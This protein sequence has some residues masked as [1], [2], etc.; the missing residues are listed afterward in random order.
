MKLPFMTA[1]RELD[2]RHKRKKKAT[3][4]WQNW[5]GL[6]VEPI[7]NYQKKGVRYKHT[8][9]Q[10]S[11]SSNSR[12]LQPSRAGYE[13]TAITLTRR[14]FHFTYSTHFKGVYKAKSLTL[15]PL[16]H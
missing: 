10:C 15:I 2:Q 12:K 13:N 8:I 7:P 4:K 9:S 3:N 5:K 1:D 16:L 11:T 6:S 14:K